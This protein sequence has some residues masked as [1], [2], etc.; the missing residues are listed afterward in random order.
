MSPR[1]LA[2]LAAVVL[3]LL[4][5][6]ASAHEFQPCVLDVRELDGGRYEV[7]WKAAPGEE[8]GAA[9]APIFPAHCRREASND[10]PGE[11]SARWILACGPDGLSGHPI[12]VAGLSPG[13]TDALLRFA[14]A[15]GVAL[16]AVLRA[17]NPSFAIPGASGGPRP[18]VA[19]T[20]LGAGVEHLLGGWDHLLF[21][22]GLLLLVPRPRALVG[23]ITAF[24]AAHSVS[25]ALATAGVVRV[26]AA[27]A[28]AAIA[29]SLLF[30]ARELA[31]PAPTLARR[32]PWL[33][34]FAFGLIHGLGFAGGLRALGLPSGQLPL[35]LLAF[36]LGLE[37]G[38]LAF[39]AVVL[40]LARLARR[41]PLRASK[42]PAYII[43][44]LASFWLL[45]RV[46]SSWAPG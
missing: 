20:Y 1:H 5:R 34:A 37:A 6:V 38:Q 22:L 35:A 18:R 13:K 21:V 17:D 15:G 36:N 31:C 44:S 28:E 41:V 30:L 25:L 40:A 45:Q 26:P 3:L 32:W 27:P 43:G 11:P 46:A 42:V 10:A 12:A 19:A 24:T 16:T 23:T 9:P 33:M 39:V 4:A 29:L 2:G 14:G 7:T 8:P